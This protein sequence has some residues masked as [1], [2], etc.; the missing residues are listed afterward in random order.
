M[1]YLI[2]IIFL[3]PLNAYG[4]NIDLYCERQASRNDLTGLVVDNY[5]NP[6]AGSWKRSSYVDSVKVEIRGNQGAFID[7]KA[8]GLFNSTRRE[9]RNLVIND[10]NITALY[11]FSFLDNPKI[12]INRYTG[13]TLITTSI[14]KKIQYECTAKEISKEKL[15]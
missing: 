6:I 13:S 5:G 9:L 1:R 14:N 8:T 12:N 11:T 10:S 7:P 3:I 15:F 2:I 4:I